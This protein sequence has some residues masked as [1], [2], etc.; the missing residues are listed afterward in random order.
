MGNRRGAPSWL[1]ALLAGV[2]A[3]AGLASLYWVLR[4]A[5]V[6]DDVATRAT[7]ASYGSSTILLASAALASTAAVLRRRKARTGSTLRWFRPGGHIERDQATDDGR[8]WSGP[9]RTPAAGDRPVKVADHRGRWARH[10]QPQ[11]PSPGPHVQPSR[12]GR[13]VWDTFPETIQTHGDHGFSL[14]PTPS[15]LAGIDPTGQTEVAQALARTLSPP[16]LHGR[17]HT[18]TAI[19][20]SLLSDSQYLW[21]RGEPWAGKTAL[22]A[23]LV[24]NP[25]PDAEVVSFFVVS[26]LLGSND[27]RS[28]AASVTP[29]LANVAKLRAGLNVTQNSLAQY[30][31]LLELADQECGQTGKRLILVVDGIDEDRGVR[32][33][34]IASALPGAHLTNTRVVVTSRYEPELPS[35]LAPDHPLRHATHYHLEPWEFATELRKRASSELAEILGNGRPLERSL[36]ALA[37]AASD[38]LT[39]GDMASLLQVDAADIRAC[40]RGPFARVFRRTST[41]SGTTAFFLAHDMLARAASEELEEDAAAYRQVLISW[42]DQQLL[43]PS[44]CDF[45]VLSYPKFLTKT[46][47]TQ[48]AA[49]IVM[50]PGWQDVAQA[51]SGSDSHAAE[52]IEGVAVDLDEV[53]DRDEATLAVLGLMRARLACRAP[54]PPLEALELLVRGGE[55]DIA[56]QL[57][58]LTGIGDLRAVGYAH[59]AAGAVG[60]RSRVGTQLSRSEPN[61]N[62]GHSRP[63]RQTSNLVNRQP[64]TFGRTLGGF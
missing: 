60:S 53:T 9:D 16:V 26:R 8:A 21:I 57:V 31:R 40:F 64:H 12:H 15:A 24:L 45:A 11:P 23:D 48:K 18:K 22:A 41:P 34:S 37:V 14:P 25:P 28:Y 38:A 51:R 36:I 63:E 55:L 61:R 49:S 42:C 44:P 30:L 1:D 13:H 10:S 32:H 17:K 56:Q 7:I 58:S 35:D 2:L 20:S 5:P 33:G 47:H 54:K 3:V 39:I 29:Q 6:G 50:S 52:L 62:H 43:D 27:L 46:G 59:L 19:A 4:G